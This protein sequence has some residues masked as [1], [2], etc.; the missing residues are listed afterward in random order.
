M[1]NRVPGNILTETNGSEYILLLHPEWKTNTLKNLVQ[2]C[3]TP[4]PVAGI[5]SYVLKKGNTSKP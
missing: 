4:F 2:S 3:T 1:K 5:S